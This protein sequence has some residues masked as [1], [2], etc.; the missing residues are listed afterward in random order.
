MTAYSG[1]ITIAGAIQDSQG[2]HETFS[3]SLT[4]HINATLDQSRNGVGTE[5]V[6]ST[7]NVYIIYANGT[8]T[9]GTVP[10]DIHT[11]SFA[12]SPGQFKTTEQV[13]SQLVGGQFGVTLSGVALH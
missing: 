11:P 1:T 5:T 7:L 3:V 4:E 12:F 9:S 13:S 10:F 8:Y 6:D 2:D